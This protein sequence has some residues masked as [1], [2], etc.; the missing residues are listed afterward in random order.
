M[1]TRHAI[2]ATLRFLAV[3]C[4]VGGLYVGIVYNDRKYDLVADADAD[5]TIASFASI[6]LGS[7]DVA[8]A[9]KDCIIKLYNRSATL[10]LILFM[11]K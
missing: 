1:I 5:S 11:I 10:F 3:L 7:F 6:E 9:Y 4:T 2:S 8:T